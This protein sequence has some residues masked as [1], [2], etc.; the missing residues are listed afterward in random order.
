MADVVQVA[1]DSLPPRNEVGATRGERLLDEPQQ[2]LAQPLV[3]G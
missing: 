2:L 1:R 3:L